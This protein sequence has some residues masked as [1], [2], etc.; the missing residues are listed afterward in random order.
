MYRSGATTRSAGWQDRS[1]FDLASSPSP[2]P[3][4]DLF[5]VKGLTFCEEGLR[6]SYGALYRPVTGKPVV[7]EV[8][9]SDSAA[10]LRR[11]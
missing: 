2:D 3:T 11:M 1:V 7:M 6:A 9:G 8:H 10:Q 5:R 4:S